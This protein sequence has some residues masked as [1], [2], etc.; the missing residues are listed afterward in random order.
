MQIDLLKSAGIHFTAVVGHSSGEIAAAYAAGMIS[1]EDAICIAY[2]RGLN[3]SLARGTHNQRGT[4]M[5]V[6]S[7]YDDIAALCEEPEL[8][9]RVCIAAINSPAS[10]TLSGDEDAIEET[11]L[12][13]ED[14][15]KFVRLLKVDKA[16]HSHHMIPCSA[17]YLRS[18]STL[19]IQAHA[20]VG[21]TWYS[22]V[23]NGENMENHQKLL[24]EI[25]WER[26]MVKPVLFMQAVEK[27]C[28]SEGRFDAAIEVRPH[29]ALKS[30]TLQT[31][32]DIYG[33]EIPYLGLSRRGENAIESFA[34]ALGSIW[35]YLGSGSVDIDA[36]DRF[37]SGTA[38]AQLIGGLP[39]YAWNHEAEYWHES[40]FAKAIRTRPDAVHELLGHLT[41]DSKQEMRW[42][43][44]L[45]PQEVPWLKC[46]RLQ[47]QT[48]FPAAGYVVA[49]AEAANMLCEGAATLIEIS[50]LDIHKGLTFNNDGS[51]VETISSL[52]DI[53][54]HSSRMIEAQFKYYAAGSDQDLLD[55]LASGSIRII[56]GAHHADILPDRTP[57]QPNLI[58]VRSAD[59]YT[60]LQEYEYEYSGPFVS[61]HSIERKFGVARGLISVQEDT[62]M[63]VHPATL[64]AAFQ[65]L[66]LAHSFPGDGRLWSM[67]VPKTIRCVRFNPQLCLVARSQGNRLAFD[68][69]QP[70]D[71]TTLE[72]D[73]HVY[74]EGTNHAMIQTEGLVC[75]PF[76]K[77]TAQQDVDMFSTMVWDVAAP[78]VEMLVSD[79]LSTATERQLAN[80]L[81]RIA[82]FYLCALDRDVPKDHATRRSGPL[83]SLYRFAS[84]AL[85]INCATESLS[86]RPGWLPAWQEDTHEDIRDLCERFEHIV[87]IKL[88]RA[89]GEELIAI[90]TG[91]R[92][93]IEIGMNE[94]LLAHYYEKAIGMSAYSQYLARAVKQIVHKYPHM[95][96]LEI[97]A[98]TGGATKGIFGSIGR[99]FASYTFTDISSGFFGAANAVFADRTDQMIFKV[100]D[101]SQDPQEQGF[102]DHS[103]DMIVASMV[104][105]ATPKLKNTMRNVRRL[106]KPGGY[107]VVLEGN[108]SHAFRIGAIF[109]AFPGWW[110]GADDGRTLSP[111]ID[112]C[113]WDELLRDSGFSGCDTVIPNP[114][115]LVM[116]LTLFVSQAVNEK[117]TFL[118]D[119]LSSSPELLGPNTRSKGILLL[120]GNSLKSSRLIHQLR[121]VLQPFC[122]SIKAIRT[123]AEVASIESSHFTTFLSLLDLEEPV[124]ARITEKDWEAF[125][126]MLET[127][128]E[129]LWVTHDRRAGNPYSNMVTG[130]FRACAR[131][132]PTLKTQLLDVVN[133]KSL[134]A[135]TLAEALL[136]LQVSNAWLR[137]DAT[138]ALLN[139]MEPELLLNREGKYLIPP[140][141][142]ATQGFA[143]ENNPLRAL[144][145]VHLSGYKP[146]IP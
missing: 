72:G 18:L 33:L 22:S 6:G 121:T 5:A 28:A 4:M 116:P 76:S 65:S 14:E 66:L 124:F 104:L 107:L 29:P 87:D 115:P 24:N 39:T 57:R 132:V 137:E 74:Q 45:R 127:A 122:G 99:A 146:V 46:H 84:H 2:Y 16:Y 58:K 83:I 26:N 17:P 140:F 38:R 101:I 61:L 90:A 78:E 143:S 30:P 111:C 135:R 10:V 93:A 75:V 130:V 138:E 88:L 95:H 123:L 48:V 129:I 73:I 44:L 25:Y 106:L 128:K 13:L 12:I 20:S 92:Q 96:I 86:Q 7:S 134:H 80:I 110:L 100:L 136:R 41:P 125:K 37:A 112:I 64:D 109:G 144:T 23:L 40:R 141:N 113:H 49:A 114:D 60:Q 55:L 11:R 15:R 82:F 70:V 71:H 69:V 79:D 36:F 32:T 97:G 35:T 9:Q 52:S 67:H 53:V 145:G 133:L 94:N 126:V 89:I 1:A 68:T 34:D 131:E 142:N 108:E 117:I 120:G 98:G 105:H 3:C 118:R 50:E 102:A 85:S 139:T 77:A 47:N 21:C 43:H 54:R 81:E 51:G 42:R 27:A 31:I 19:K 8:K 103:Y 63:L 91:E 59:F 119:P 56:L 62:S